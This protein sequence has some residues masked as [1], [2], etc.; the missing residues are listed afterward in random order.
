MMGSIKYRSHL[1][2][3]VKS[4]LFFTMLYFYQQKYNY[5]RMG[6]RYSFNDQDRTISRQFFFTESLIF[7]PLHVQPKGQR[8]SLLL[9]YVTG[10]FSISHLQKKTNLNRNFCRL[11]VPTTMDSRKLVTPAVMSSKEEVCHTR[12]E[13]LCI[14]LSN[15]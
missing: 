14:A 7:L 4:S 9:M 8:Q 13:T 15:L 6:A 12:E 1:K 3:L 2:T 5:Y 11:I 10:I